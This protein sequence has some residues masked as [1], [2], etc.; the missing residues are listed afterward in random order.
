MIFKYKYENPVIY[1][2][3]EDIKFCYFDAKS[4]KKFCYSW[5]II[6]KLR[7]GARF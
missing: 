3:E 1:K 6:E 4:L 7:V 5:E 2:T